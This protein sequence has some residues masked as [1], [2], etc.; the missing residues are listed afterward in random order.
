[1]FE[2]LNGNYKNKLLQI[3]AGYF[4]IFRPEYFHFEYGPP[5]AKVFFCICNFQRKTTSHEGRTKIE[6]E[7]KASQEMLQILQDNFFTYN[8]ATWMVKTDD[9]T[10][11]SPEILVVVKSLNTD[12]Q[13]DILGLYGDA[14]LRYYI[15]RYLF[16]KYPQFNEGILTRITSEA[17][18]EE[19]RADA[20]RHLA[21]EQ[22]VRTEITSRTLAQALSATIGKLATTVSDLSCRDFIMTHYKSFMDLS[23]ANL[24]TSQTLDADLMPSFYIETRIHNYKNEILEYAQKKSLLKPEYSLLSKSGDAHAPLFTVCCHFQGEDRIGEGRTVKS[25]EQEA[26]QLMLSHITN[27]NVDNIRRVLESSSGHS[28][29]SRLKRFKAPALYALKQCIGWYH[30]DNLEYL[31]E[32]FTH[33]SKN[34]YINYQRLEFLGDALLKKILLAHIIKSY[35]SLSEKSFVSSRVDQLVSESTQVRIAE[36]L[37]LGDHIFSAVVA[38]PSMLSDVLEALISAVFLDAEIKKSNRADKVVVYWYAKE[39]EKLFGKSFDPTSL[40]KRTTPISNAHHRNRFLN[41]KP[42]TI[43][44]RTLMSGGELLEQGAALII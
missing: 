16:D 36:R 17:L 24:L 33:P 44:E 3:S 18:R 26:S 42:K 6:A 7:Q 41:S 31:Q 23:V 30:F 15:A 34:Q 39:I 10:I 5:H 19:T 43:V 38:S 25:A 12:P 8:H 29:F 2:A 32:A 22:C 11:V 28:C 35:P 27:R 40:R 14:I 20:A 4:G 37:R 1:M 13:F 21:L 9:S